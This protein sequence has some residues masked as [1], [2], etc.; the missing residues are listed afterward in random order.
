MIPNTFKGM[1]RDGFRAAEVISDANDHDSVPLTELMVFPSRGCSYGHLL[2]REIP[3]QLWSLHVLSF[4]LIMTSDTTIR[5]HDHTLHSRCRHFIKRAIFF[6]NSSS[7]IISSH[8]PLPGA[9]TF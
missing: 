9:G 8:G 4:G 7:L 3:F 6:P 2:W 1:I 5:G